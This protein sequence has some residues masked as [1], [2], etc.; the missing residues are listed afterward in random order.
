MQA[1]AAAAAALPGGR[2]VHVR[3]A[4]GERW[5]DPSLAE[6]PEKAHTIFVG[7]LGKEVSDEVLSRAFGRYP[8]FVK[9]RV[10]RVKATGEHKGFG[11][12]AFGDAVA[13]A[14]AL[15]E[16]DGQYIG[17]RPCKLKK[18]TSGSRDAGLAVVTHVRTTVAPARKRKHV[19][20]L[21]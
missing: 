10:V 11:F 15:R 14:K 13:M 8:G 4:A 9:A 12:A 16:Q 3:Q 21:L 20:T 7:D 6:W 1:A 2:V 5:V 18:S 19:A 17:N